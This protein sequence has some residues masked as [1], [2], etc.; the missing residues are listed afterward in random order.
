[1]A[2][3]LHLFQRQ[4]SLAAPASQST[5]A[6]PY[7]QDGAKLMGHRQRTTLPRGMSSGIREDTSLGSPHKGIQVR[8]RREED[9]SNLPACRN[10]TA[11]QGTY[12]IPR[13]PTSTH[14]QLANQG[15]LI[16]LESL[17]MWQLIPLKTGRSGIQPGT[18]T[19]TNNPAAVYWPKRL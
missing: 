10:N 8:Q 18:G 2:G 12:N 15:M 1:M 19:S 6:T 17:N 5:P 9:G 14:R 4:S 13:N 3:L 7:S 11:S 16:F